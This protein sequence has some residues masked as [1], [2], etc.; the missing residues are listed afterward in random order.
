MAHLRAWRSRG[1]V[2]GAPCLAS[3]SFCIE[4]VEGGQSRVAVLRLDLRRD[5]DLGLRRGLG[6]W[7]SAAVSSGDSSCSGSSFWSGWSSTV[8]AASVLPVVDKK[9]SA[10]ASAGAC[11]GLDRR[12]DFGIV[13]ILWR[14]I[15]A[16]S[17][18]AGVA[19]SGSGGAAESSSGNSIMGIE[20]GAGGVA[21]GWVA[22]NCAG[23][24]TDPSRTLRAGKSGCATGCAAWTS[25]A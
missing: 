23:A 24:C 15:G 20:S 1:V 6:A 16:E 18:G 7:R 9:A 10:R 3:V 21:R 14:G 12:R 5:L 4:G 2:L 22:R 25:S 13:F 8:S 19:G 11:S 17:R